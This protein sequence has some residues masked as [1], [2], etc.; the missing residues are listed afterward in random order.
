MAGLA[1]GV[2]SFPALAFA[3]TPANSALEPAVCDGRTVSRITIQR[4]ERTIVDRAGVP[5]WSRPVLHWLLLGTPTRET[6]IRP[7]VQLREGEPCTEMRR[8]ESERLLR[9]QP[10]LANAT[11]RVVDEPDGRVAIEVETTDDLRRIVGLGLDGARPTRIELGDANIEGTGRLAAASWRDGGAYRDGLAVRGVSY[12]LF[13]GPNLARFALVRA[14]L[15]SRMS[16]Q[17]GRPFYTD[18]Q[19]AA[20]MMGYDRDDSYATFVRP[21]G[22]PLALQVVTERQDLGV[23]WRLNNRGL[24][25]LLGGGIVLREQRR[26]AQNAVVITDSGLVEPTDRS[27]SARYRTT[28]RTRIGLV[29]GV[30]ALRFAKVAGFDALEGTQD[31]SRGVQLSTIFGASVGGEA[32]GQFGSAGLFLGVGTAQSYV[33]LRALADAQQ[34]DGGWRDVVASGRVAWYAKPSPKRTRIVSAEFAGAWQDNIP[35]QLTLDEPNTGVRGYEGSR[36]AGARRL[37]ARYEHRVILPGARRYMG[38][39]VAAFAD[40]AHMWRGSVPF[41]TTTTR[42]SAGVSLLAAV[43][44]SSRGLGR[45]DIAVPLVPDDGAGAYV[46]RVGWQITG[47]EFWREPAAITRARVAGPTSGIFVWP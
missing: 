9:L 24:F 7:F 4:S 30:R 22:D 12:H 45:V 3:Q 10:Y 17:A 13:G 39:G 47:R 33:G 29:A 15:G 20:G 36:V 11:V 38:M 2:G 35:Y 43:P 40:G 31:V 6:A 18:L 5:K 21:S 26:V 32:R 8:A 46:V 25:R 19:Q 23:V 1:I 28:E 16:L 27:L 44:R 41:G 42:A 37:I 14:P 34:V